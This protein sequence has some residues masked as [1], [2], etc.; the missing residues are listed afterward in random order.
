MDQFM[1][2]KDVTASIMVKSVAICI[3]DLPLGSL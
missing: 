3:F 2:I 1:H